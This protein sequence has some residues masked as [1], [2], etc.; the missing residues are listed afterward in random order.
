MAL[1]A[2]RRRTTG[3]LPVAVLV[4]I[5]FTTLILI[6]RADISPT[7]STPAAGQF[8]LPKFNQRNGR[9]FYQV[10]L[11]GY[12]GAGSETLSVPIA[13]RGGPAYV[14]RVRQAS[15]QAGG[16]R[17]GR[18]KAS[19]SDA[20]QF[21]NRIPTTRS[22]TS[23]LRAETKLTESPKIHSA[24]SVLRNC[25]VADLSPTAHFWVITPIGR[26]NRNGHNSRKFQLTS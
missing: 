16:R 20:S 24:C 5:S 14:T 4:V 13:L 1:A 6:G 9:K 10:T 18:R 8:T 7:G 25:R 23:C 11:L 2:V 22:L 19:S 26:S 3:L 15:K 12:S 21:P 17:S